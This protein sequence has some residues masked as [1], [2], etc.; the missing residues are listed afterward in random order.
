MA[1]QQDGAAGVRIV[2][3]QVLERK[4]DGTE[5]A[6]SPHAAVETAQEL[7]E[8]AAKAEGDARIRLSE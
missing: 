2:S 5:V 3:G 6:M 4:P 8:A 7:L 1:D